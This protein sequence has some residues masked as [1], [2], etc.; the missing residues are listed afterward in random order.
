MNPK[1]EKLRAEQK[2]VQCEL[3]QAQHQQQRSVIHTSRAQANIPP[4]MS[5]GCLLGVFSFQFFVSIAA[6]A[7]RSRSITLS[8]I[9]YQCCVVFSRKK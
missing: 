7:W 9:R 2:R 5:T 1:L 3:E 4:T 6:G 8:A